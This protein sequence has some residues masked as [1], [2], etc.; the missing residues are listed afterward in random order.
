MHNWACKRDRK[1][2]RANNALKSERVGMNCGVTVL[3]W[4]ES[5]EVSVTLVEQQSLV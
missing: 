5:L 2:S 1:S 3:G 4:W